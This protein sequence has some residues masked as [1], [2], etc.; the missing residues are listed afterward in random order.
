MGDYLQKIVFGPLGMRN[1]GF[2]VPPGKLDNFAEYYRQKPGVDMVSQASAS[3]NPQGEIEKDILPSDI[4]WK[5]IQGNMFGLSVQ[6]V[7]PS[8]DSGARGLHGSIN[9]YARYCA[10]I[11]NGGTFDGIKVLDKKTRDVLLSDLTPQLT[12]EDFRRGFGEGAAFMKFGA[13]YG[14]KY[15]GGPGEK[16]KVDYHFWGGAHNTFFWIDTANGHIGVFATNH[17]PPQYNISDAIEQIVDE[18]KL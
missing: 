14:I 10:M 6:Q 7:R 17:S 12:S 15:I 2:F 8:Y 4:D 1:S 11:L 16:T 9:D 18:A 3:L 5:I 13:G